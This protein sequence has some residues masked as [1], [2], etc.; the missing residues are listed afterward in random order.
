[1]ERWRAQDPEQHCEQQHCSGDEG[2]HLSAAAHRVPDNRAAATAANEK[3]GELPSTQVGCTKGQEL[4]A[5]S[6]RQCLLPGRRR[7]T[8]GGVLCVK[9]MPLAAPSTLV[10]GS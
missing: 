3:S 5:S 1:M 9:E 2:V 7:H 10:C 4:L 6:R 8:F